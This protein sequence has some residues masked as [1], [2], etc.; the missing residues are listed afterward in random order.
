METHK[1]AGPYVVNDDTIEKNMWYVVLA[2]I[3]AVIA[4]IILFGFYSLYLILG[5]AIFSVLIEMPFTKDRGLGDGSAFLAG[6]LLGLTLPPSTVWW[7]PLVG[8]FLVIVIAKQLFGGIG[9]NIFNPALVARGILL[10]A[11][12]PQLTRWEKP[13]EAITTATPLAEYTAGEALG[14][15]GYFDLFTGNIAGS[16]GE[17]SALALLIGALFLYIKGYIGWRIP[18]S[19]IVS[20]AVMA[21]ILGIDPLFTILSGGLLFGALYMATDMVSSPVTKDARVIY[22]IGCGILTVII[23]E[24]TIYPE[25]ITF[26][27]LLMNGASYLFDSLLEGPRFGQ[28]E[29]RK[30]SLFRLGSIILASVIFL[31]ISYSSF[32]LSESLLEEEVKEEEIQYFYETGEYTGKGQGAYGE[33][34]IKVFVEDNFIEDIIIVEHSDTENIAEPAFEE[35][36]EKV[37]NEQS[38]EVDIITD[39]TVS[40]QGFLEAL[41]DALSKAR[42]VPKIGSGQGMNGEIVIGLIDDDNQIKEIFI[43]EHSDTE[44]V[45]EPAFEELTEKVINEQSTEVDTISGATAS[46]QGFLEALE[47]ALK[48]ADLNE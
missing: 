17:T 29:L 15:F 22:G 42:R 38:T 5:T 30:K 27:I 45:A 7:I 12:T 48:E 1:L 44:N 41:E 3:P 25:G 20:A 8:A 13:F 36:T 26:A 6:M 46:S 10:L 21:F 43:V 2:L 47:D 40:S 11:W 28:V 4:A 37:I 9:N 24:Y 16:I 33:I 14:I 32:M 35:L 31:T 18:V 39:A 34:E 19:Y 23:R